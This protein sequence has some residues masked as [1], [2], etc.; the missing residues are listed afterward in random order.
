MD[1]KPWV[2]TQLIPSSGGGARIGKTFLGAGVTVDNATIELSGAAAPHGRA[3]IAPITKAGVELRQS[4][5]YYPGNASPT[6]HIFGVKYSPW[7]LRGRFMDSDLGPGGAKAMVEKV[8]AFIEDQL[9]CSIAWGD[10]LSATGI[11]EAFEAAPEAEDQWGWTL[12][13]GIDK[14]DETTSARNVVRPTN[15]AKMASGIPLTDEDRWPWYERIGSEL[16]NATAAGQHAV[17]ACSALKRAY[18]DRLA[19]DVD[20]RV[21]YL[22]G[23]AATIEPRLAS[24][25]G[26][27]MPVSLL[28]S[29]YATLEEPAKAIVVDIAQPVAAQVAAITRALRERLP[30]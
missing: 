13:F 22:K 30:A 2:F 29:Q 3:R 6:R 7:E 5:T 28:A 17:L 8:F 23:D 4:V 19:R 20:L 18:R 24:R 1:P 27:F 26:H 9:P 21:V 10:I 14:R 11:L 16:R 25:R 12:R 15:V